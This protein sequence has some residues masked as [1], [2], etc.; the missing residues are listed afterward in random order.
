MYSNYGHN[1][2]KT[3]INLAGHRNKISVVGDQIG[4]PTNAEDL[5][6]ATIQILRNNNYKWT[7]GETFHYSNEGAVHG[8]SLGRNI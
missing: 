7:A 8:M 2:V 5:A 3:M 6:N 1:F 4:S